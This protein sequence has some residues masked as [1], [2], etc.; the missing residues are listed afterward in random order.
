MRLIRLNTVVLP[1]PLGPISVN[2]SP[3]FTSML[4]SLTASTPPKR[5]LR[6]FAESNKSVI[7]RF[8]AVARRICLPLR[9]PVPPRNR[10]CRAAG[11]APLRGR[12]RRRFGG[13]SFQPVRFLEGLLAL[14]QALAVEREQLQVGPH[15]EPAAVEAQRLEQHEADQHR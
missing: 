13:G 12:R 3:R 4:S 7:S 9:N 15:L 1:A 6:F 8:R 11:G 2:T 10:L 5:T 14:E